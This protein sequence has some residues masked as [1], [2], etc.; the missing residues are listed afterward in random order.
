MAKLKFTLLIKRPFEKATRRIILNRYIDRDKPWKSRIL[1][2]DLNPILAHAWRNFEELWPGAPATHTFG[3][4]HATAIA[5]YTLAIYRALRATDMNVDYATELTSDVVWTFHLPWFPILNIVGFIS[6]G[7]NAQK[8]VEMGLRGFAKYWNP[9]GFEFRF[10]KDTGRRPFRINVIKCGMHT[11]FKSFG[12]EE[13]NLFYKTHCM[14][15]YSVIRRMVKGGWYERSNTL[16]AGHSACT[17]SFYAS[18]EGR[19]NARRPLPIGT[20]PDDSADIL[21]SKPT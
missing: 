3:N 6:A 4:W 20:P 8:R 14:L 21:D 5:V 9:P 16:S 11:Y 10:A 15:D 13:M 19:E 18:P 1:A 7:K 2:E 12:E 17:M